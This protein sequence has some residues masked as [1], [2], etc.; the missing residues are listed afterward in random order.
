MEQGQITCCFLRGKHDAVIRWRV[1][2]I[3]SMFI[4]YMSIIGVWNYSGHVGELGLD[5]ELA[6]HVP[7]VEVERCSV[8]AG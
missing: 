7:N 5:D 6:G 4:A 3:F 8:H 2:N 1:P